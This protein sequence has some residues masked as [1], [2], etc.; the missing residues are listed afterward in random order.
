MCV[1]DLYGGQVKSPAL[2][3]VPVLAAGEAPC[4]NNIFFC[5]FLR[6]CGEGLNHQRL[7]PLLNILDS[8][9]I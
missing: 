5:R 8:P 4:L 6:T 2:L 7:V 3:L 9:A 1:R